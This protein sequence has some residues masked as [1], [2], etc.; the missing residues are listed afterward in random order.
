MLTAEVGMGWFN[1]CE[2][3]NAFLYHKTK[4][5]INIPKQ[6]KTKRSEELDVKKIFNPPSF[7]APVVCLLLPL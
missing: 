4:I 5:I 7:L 1:V 3:I 6:N 2:N